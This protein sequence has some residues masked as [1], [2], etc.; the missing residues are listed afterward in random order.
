MEMKQ[1]PL[2]TQLDILWR[3][4]PLLPASDCE[5]RQ[6][7]WKPGQTIR[8]VL[9]ANGV[10]PHQPI[11]IVLD[12]R[13][14]TVEEWDTISPQPGQIIN[15]KAEV[16][17]GGGGGGS[18]A[19]QVVAMV[20]LVV[21]AIAIQQYELVPAIMG[22]SAGTASAM[23]AGVLLVAGSAVISSVFAAQTPAMSMGETSGQYAS[24][25]P[26]YSLSGGQNRTR[27]YESMP[28]IMGVHR[29][30]PDNA[31]KPF[32]EYH[33]EDQYLY[34]VF[35][36]GLSTTDKSDWRIG[37]NPISN[38]TNW[39]WTYADSAGRINDFP[40]NV[41]STPGAVLENS[42][43]WIVR[44]TSPDTYRIGIDI[45]GTMYYANNGGG[46]D[47][48]SVQLRVQYKPSNSP[49]WIEPSQITTSGS[50]FVSGSYQPYYVKITRFRRW[51]GGSHAETTEI[52][53]SEYDSA[54]SGELFFYDEEGNVAYVSIYDYEQR[55]RFVAGSGGTIIVSG[56]SQAPRRASLFIDVPI[57]SYDV[58]VIRDTGDTTDARLQNKTN[59]STLRSYQADRANYN[60]QSRIGLSIKASEQ[61]NGTI[62]QLSYMAESYAS[63]W[64]GSAWTFEK[65]SNPAH[66]FMDF[67]RGRFDSNGNLLYGLGMSESQIDLAGLNAWATFC[68]SEGLS[69]NAVLDRNLTAAD[70]LT[71]IARCGFGSPSW[72]SGRLGVVWDGRNATA[73]AAFG[74]SNIIRGSFEVSYITEQLA[75]E[76]IVRF[77]NPAKDWTQD[78]VR[79][80]VPGITNPT[81]TSTVDLM[82]CTNASM[83]GKFA[84]YLA[85]QQYYRRRRVKWECDFEGFVCQRG[86]VVLLSHDLTQWGYSGR[87]VQT[88]NNVLTLDRAVPRSGGVEYLMIKRPDGTMTTYSVTAGTGESDTVTLTGAAPSLQAD[89]LAMDHVWFFSPLATPGKKVKI[90]NVQPVSESRVQVVATDED[91]KFYAAWDG[92]FQTSTSQTLLAPSTPV[93]SNLKISERLTVI[94]TGQ[95]VTR[96]TFSWQQKTSQLERI[97][98]R[99]RINAGA[100]QTA[101]VYSNQSF[102]VDFD[103]YGLVEAT[104]V[105]INGP[106]IGAKLSASA[107]VYGKTLPPENVQG[108]TIDALAT[109]FTLS[110]NSVSD[111][112]LDGYQIRWINGNSRDW[113]QAAPIHDG[114]IVTS[115]YVSVVRP[116]GFGTLM[117]KAVDTSGNYSVTPAAIVLDL[118]DAPVDNVVEIINLGGRGYTGWVVNGAVS[119]GQ[120]LANEV[121]TM[122][123]VN[124]DANMWT[125]DSA[126]MWRSAT[127]AAMVYTDEFHTPPGCVGSQLTLPASVTAGSWQIQYRL[128][129]ATR[130]WSND[131]AAMWNANS[132]VPMFVTGSTPQWSA[133]SSQLMWNAD[134]N[135]D[136]WTFQTPLMAWPGAVTA[137]DDTYQIRISTSFG[138]T[139]GAISSLKASFDVPDI[140]EVLNDIN[141]TPAGI[142]LPITKDYFAIRAVNLQLQSGTTAA[143]SVKVLDKD[144]ALGPMVQCYDVSGNPIAGLIDARIKGF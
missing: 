64:N 37:T 121:G 66:W 140:E 12:D 20:A 6:Q 39:N 141:V 56:A 47:A 82:G 14:L 131:G 24:A 4:H 118:G 3:P 115:P 104:A 84:N 91:P 139:R 53:K 102:D 79:T 5:L 26:T 120:V 124:E 72:A 38:Y 87:L 136:M 50:G 2:K 93:I 132:G 63:Y 59:W 143:F 111:V 70:L 96:I 108:F 110:W 122:W 27:P 133:D 119:G 75:E 41:D 114:L 10:D 34:Q 103:G 126:S 106:F 107:Q 142:R 99:Y 68:A 22:M 69:F 94:G 43:G 40:G 80:T 144:P 113:G 74:M 23:A 19:L 11:V 83:A 7:T 65:T 129:D 88:E 58:R 54:R 60:G 98:L 77:T 90:L 138:G 46:L 51:F 61:L 48:T 9:L 15:V 30:I 85:A 44:S 100:W 16:E 73:V 123:N 86:D 45:E 57:G 101:S 21:V 42:A 52:S 67:A 31:A 116:A 128:V 135:S 134:S 29:H 18:N 92:S 78:E 95:I 1:S 89:M 105:P 36:L 25:S 117:I 55:W 130:M 13:L 125:F 76:I 112:D 28:V 127:Y 32:T 97:E 35:H 109:R 137:T 81:R 17:G 71:A 62:Q 49:T 8:E 33:G